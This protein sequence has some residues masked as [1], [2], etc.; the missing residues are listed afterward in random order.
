VF[1]H[2]H[3]GDND[4]DDDDSVAVI[5][6]ATS[7]SVALGRVTTTPSNNPKKSQSAVRVAYSSTNVAILSYIN[8]L[9]TEFVIH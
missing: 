2:L 4:D 9:F 3:H 5:C 7:P 6:P 8:V 1:L